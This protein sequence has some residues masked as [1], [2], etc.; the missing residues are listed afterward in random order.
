MKTSILFSIIAAAVLLAVSS[1]KLTAGDAAKEVTLNGNAVCSKC[2]LKETK[3]CHNVLQVSDSG[4]TTSCYL[5]ENDVS[6]NFHDQICG[7][8]GEK[9]SV[10]G[11]VS[12]KDGK[13]VITA[14]KI[15]PEK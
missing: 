8:S 6:K 7:T 2:V 5:A 15:T 9:V 1:Q 11:T 12:E 14:S 10:T 3:E 4:K 13:Q